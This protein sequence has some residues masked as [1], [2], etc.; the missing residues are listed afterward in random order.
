[1]SSD[2]PKLASSE[3]PIMDVIWDH[4][5]VAVRDVVGAVNRD[6]EKAVTRNTV[7]K[8]IQRLEAK[9]W[10]VRVAGARP[11]AYRAAAGREIAERSMTAAL[12]DTMFNGSPLALVRSL[13]GEGVLSSEEI[14]QLREM[15][16]AAEIADGRTGR[17]EGGQ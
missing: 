5:P 10:V 14:R 1:M 13:I 3:V 2:L 15:I 9:G 17:E 11:T 6:R 16:E 8:Q 7:L 4:G 12:R